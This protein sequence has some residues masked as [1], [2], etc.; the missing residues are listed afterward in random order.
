MGLPGLRALAFY[1]QV[2]WIVWRARCKSVRG[3]YGHEQ[4]ARS[5]LA[6]LQAVERCGGTVEITG[7]DHLRAAPAPVV[8]ISNH[9]STLET[10]VLGTMLIPEKPMTYVVKD[11]LLTHAFFGPVMRSREPIA[12]TRTNPREDLKT[13]LKQGVAKLAA[14]TSLVVFPQST[15]MVGFVVSR[16]NS[17]GAKLAE[18]AGVAVV[19][20]ALQTNFWGN[21]KWIKECGPVGRCKEVRFA[22]GPAIPAGTP[23]RQTQAAVVE[24]LHQ[25][26]PAWGIPWQETEAE[27]GGGAGDG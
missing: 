21:G 12:V 22:F 18:R 2:F 15:R 14:G 9:M 24:F 20:L 25:R 23:S 13:V 10:F 17:I 27:I 26:L 8:V 16:F 19:P 5:G 7:L 11:S 3:Q 1:P 6:T 4:Y